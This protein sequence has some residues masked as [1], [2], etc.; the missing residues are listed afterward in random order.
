MS[1][2]DTEL[3][4]T[5]TSCFRQKLKV[6]TENMKMKEVEVLIKKIP[7]KD[8]FFSVSAKEYKE[9]EELEVVNVTE[10]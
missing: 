5:S 7:V 9:L 6:N 1:G 2:N 10:K 4:D 3:L 8:S